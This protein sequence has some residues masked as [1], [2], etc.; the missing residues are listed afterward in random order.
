MEASE[1]TTLRELFGEPI[2]VYTRAQAIAD[3]ELV[4]IS[5][6]A[7]T[8]ES[9]MRYPV[10]VT[11]SVWGWIKPDRMPAWQDWAGR[12]WDVLMMQRFAIRASKPGE[13]RL[14]F[15]VLFVGG[16]GLRGMQRRRVE[17]VSVCGPDDN[18]EPCITIMQPGEE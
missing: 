12:L 13:T 14:T 8:K 16:P 3:G 17:L 15:S 10:A 4:D 11:R 18:G 5:D 2:S 9:G 1:Q 6:A 7:P